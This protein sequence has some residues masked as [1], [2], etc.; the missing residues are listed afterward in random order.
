MNHQRNKIFL[1]DNGAIIPV[2]KFG[3]DIK[4]KGEKFFGKGGKR[5]QTP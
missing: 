3:N 1:L 5:R 4:R 2:A